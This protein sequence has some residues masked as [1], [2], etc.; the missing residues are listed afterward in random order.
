MVATILV[1]WSGK[2]IFDNSKLVLRRPPAQVLED[3]Q[4]KLTTTLF[5][6]DESDDKQMDWR[7]AITGN[8]FPPLL[9]L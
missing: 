3:K 9:L 8:I 2:I 7:L 5:A 6:L 1:L 4:D